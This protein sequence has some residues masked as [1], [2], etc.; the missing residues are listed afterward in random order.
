VRRVAVYAASNGIRRLAAPLVKKD[1]RTDKQSNS[2]NRHDS[3]AIESASIKAGC[4]GIVE[5]GAP[6]QP[7]QTGK[8]QQL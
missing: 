2:A 6:D 3:L 1:E 8:V 5:H 4:S 7:H